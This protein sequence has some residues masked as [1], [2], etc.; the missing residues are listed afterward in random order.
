[1][2]TG[3]TGLLG[4]NL[5]FEWSNQGLDVIALVNTHALS[6]PGV[7]CVRC[8]LLDTKQTEETICSLD[9]AWIIH[10]AAATNVEWCERH[11]DECFCINTDASGMLAR[12]AR[13]VGSR[14]VYIS[15]DSVFSGERG[16]Y[17]E[18]DPAAPLNVYARSKLAGEQA[19]AQELPASLIVR[20]NIYGWNMQP[21][22]SLAEWMLGRLREHVTF[23]GFVDVIFCPMLVNDLGD[24]LQEMMASGMEG[25]FHVVGGEACSKYEFGYR[26]ARVFGL[27][28]L[29]VQRSSIHDSK[30]LAPRPPST[31]LNTSKIRRALGRS[32]PAVEAGLKRFKAL[33]ENGFAARLKAAGERGLQECPR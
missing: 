13:S 10:C 1:V 31:S 16:D 6:I 12:S 9:P 14:F 18:S 33:S 5:V 2:V 30:L 21:K 22:E 11:A 29:L 27:D 20:T 4:A 7:K 15:T 8:D 17:T 24:C 3:A 25:L 28:S 26:L 23:A 32:M 19:V